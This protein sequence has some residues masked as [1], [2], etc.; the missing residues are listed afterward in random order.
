M[1]N[2]ILGFTGLARSGKDTA[3]NALVSAFGAVKYSFAE[4]IRDML[5]CIGIDADTI[6]DKEATIPHLGKSLREC[7]QTLGTEW[8]RQLVHGDLWVMEAKRRIDMLVK[9]RRMVV[10]PDVRFDNEARMIQES[11]GVVIRIVR[12]GIDPVRA[13]VSEAGISDKYVWRTILNNGLEGELVHKI[14]TLRDD[15]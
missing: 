8:G 14:L 9:N 15:L 5:F 12:P 2:P 3:A 1:N 6:V 4:P 13:H 7:M 11:G 10:I